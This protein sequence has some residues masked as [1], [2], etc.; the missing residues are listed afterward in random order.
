MVASVDFMNRASTIPAVPSHPMERMP[1]RFHVRLLRPFDQPH[2]EEPSLP[3]PGDADGA[4]AV[5][6][7]TPAS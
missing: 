3:R 5:V 1:D 2:H 6:S 4:G 7:A